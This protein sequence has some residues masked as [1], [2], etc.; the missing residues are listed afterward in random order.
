MFYAE[1]KG[2]RPITSQITVPS[3]TVFA[4]ENFTDFSVTPA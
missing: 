3:F 4:S 2:R 1:Q